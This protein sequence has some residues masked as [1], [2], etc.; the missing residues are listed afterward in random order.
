MTA[1]SDLDVITE[2]IL[3]CAFRV[4]T[5]LGPGFL[6]KLY[7]NAL[8]FELERAGLPFERQKALDVWYDGIQIGRFAVDL[9][10]DSRVLV[11]LKAVKA[12]EDVHMAQSLNY[13]RASRLPA[14]LL[15]N[16]G[17]PKLEIRRLIPS[18]SW[19]RPASQDSTA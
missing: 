6:E 13:L 17:V 3:G 5:G 14:C 10:V 15:L 1:M 18:P 9:L 7:E 11:E 4:S 8:A 19:P 12:L 2:Q 16:F